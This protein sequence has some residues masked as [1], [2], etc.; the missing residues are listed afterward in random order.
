MRWFAKNIRTLLLALIL[1][2][3]VWISAVS[4]ADPDEVRPPLVVPLDIV[5]QETSLIITNDVPSAIKVTLRAPRSVWEQ[6]TAQENSVRAILDLTGLSA[7][8]HELPVQVQI[9]VRP[10]QKVLVEPE[11]V[12]VKLEPLAVRT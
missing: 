3:S 10:V 11:T 7:D 6:L 5:G 2:F 1:G 4:A 9:A 8:E 12:T